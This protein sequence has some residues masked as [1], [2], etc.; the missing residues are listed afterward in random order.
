MR[1]IAEV[2]VKYRHRTSHKFGRISDDRGMAPLFLYAVCEFF[3][4]RVGQNLA[5]DALHLG[6]RRFRAQPIG[7]RKGEILALAHSSDIG[8]P[9]LAQGILDGWP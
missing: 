5:G 7:Q 3:D 8:K 6:S 1:A 4:H 2:T 9:D